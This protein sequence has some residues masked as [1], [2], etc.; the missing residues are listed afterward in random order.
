[1]SHKWDNY[2]K[3]FEWDNYNV[4]HFVPRNDKVD[5][6]SHFI[7]TCP[8]HMKKLSMGEDVK[9]CI[10]CE[11]EAGRASSYKVAENDLAFCILDINPITEGHCLILPRRHVVW[12]HE[13]SKEET[14]SFFELARLVAKQLMEIYKPDF[15]CQYARGRR[16]PHAHLFLIPSYKNDPLD[17]YFNA[18]EGFQEAPKKL[19]AL[20]DPKSL[21][22]LAAKIRLK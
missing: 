10:F 17:R 15:I 1:M 14:A 4:H 5:S 21:S 12:W 20:A 16:I 6:G 13:M 22:R 18:L 2:S 7:L 11:I 9:K 8:L 3:L 19:V